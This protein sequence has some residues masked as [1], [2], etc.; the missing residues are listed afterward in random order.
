MS[1]AFGTL[2]YFGLK[3]F[4]TQ[5]S[6]RKEEGKHFKAIQTDSNSQ[7]GEDRLVFLHLQPAMWPDGGQSMEGAKLVGEWPEQDPM[8]SNKGLCTFCMCVW[9]EDV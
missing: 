3:P 4:D 7:V 9:C 8:K 2:Q 1:A 6:M 5:K